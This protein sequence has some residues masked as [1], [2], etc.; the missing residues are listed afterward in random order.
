[1]K[2]IKYLIVTIL[3]FVVVAACSDSVTNS[4][5]PVTISGKIV[6]GAN[7]NI[8]LYRISLKGQKSLVMSTKADNRGNF[9]MTSDKSIQEA[10]YQFT[11]GSKGVSFVLTGEDTDI[12]I[13]GNLNNLETYD[14]ELDGS[15][16]T[17]V[18][19][20]AFYN[21]INDKWPKQEI[22]RYVTENENSHW[23]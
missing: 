9:S 1:M 13:N 2:A 18:Q 16:E 19:I 23:C 14:F 7:K 6:D 4:G 22:I 5:D 10:I 21:S 11:V 8:G 15:K 3:G 20:M 17:S 12:T